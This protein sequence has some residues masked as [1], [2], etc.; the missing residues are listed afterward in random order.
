M[1]RDSHDDSLVDLTEDTHL[2][3][4][5]EQSTEDFAGSRPDR[6]REVAA[7]G[8]MAGG[9]AEVRPHLSVSRVGGDVVEADHRLAVE[10]WSE[11]G[12]LAWQGKLAER[13][14][15]GARERVHHERFARLAVDDVVEEGTERG[16]D[17]CGSGV[18]H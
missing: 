17:Q 2:R 6:D 14:D 3:V 12:G 8:Q 18:G 11:D 16:V 7:H 5:E 13:L 15:G 10:G 4:T 1:R 9:H